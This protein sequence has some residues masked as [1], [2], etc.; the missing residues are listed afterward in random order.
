M[1]TSLSTRLQELVKQQPSNSSKTSLG[2]NQ[3]STYA[4]TKEMLLRLKRS[5]RLRHSLGHSILSD[6]EF[7]LKHTLVS[8]RLM[9]RKRKRTWRSSLK[10]RQERLKAHSGTVTGT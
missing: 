1:T 9:E 7:G 3:F 2:L 4:L 6:I 5:S 10:R 8:L